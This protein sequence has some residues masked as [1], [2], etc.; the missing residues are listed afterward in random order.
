MRFL[1]W[2]CNVARVS[3]WVIIVLLQMRNISAIPWRD[4]LSY[5][6]QDDND[7]CFVLNQHA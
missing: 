7:E 2:N 3:E 4:Q 6:G 1:N 5:I